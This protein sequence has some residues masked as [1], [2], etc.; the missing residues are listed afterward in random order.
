MSLE[1]SVRLGHLQLETSL[2]ASSSSAT[3]RLEDLRKLNRTAIGAI[4]TKSGTVL[5]REGNPE[6]NYYSDGILTVNAKGLPG[7]DIDGTL[8]MLEEFNLE[9]KKPVILSLAGMKPEEYLQLVQNVRQAIGKI[10]DAIELNLSCPNVQGKPI[11]SYDPEVTEKIIAEILSEFPNLCLG[12]KIAP[13]FTEQIQLEMRAKI[14]THLD[15]NNP[16]WHVELDNKTCY[17]EDEL[18]RLSLVL[19]K[20][21]SRGLKFVSA[22]NTFPNCRLTDSNGRPIINQKANLGH[23]GL[24]GDFLR[25]ISVDN[26][27][28]LK[29][30]LHKDISIIG[31]GGVRNRQTADQFFQAGADLVAIGT[32]LIEHGPKVVQ[33]I[34]LS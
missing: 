22:T 6:T 13:F 21:Q 7:P 16:G 18:C 15:Q 25:P 28:A 3:A 11:I 14:Q 26:V 23:A 33:Q 20:L 30:S 10:F 1:Q 32:A 31:T 17:G 34:L 2:L 5:E 19:N 9:R 4:I 24:S 27:R 8:K 29:T 12:V